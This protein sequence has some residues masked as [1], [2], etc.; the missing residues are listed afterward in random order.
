M[1]KE[2]D[3]TFQSRDEAIMDMERLLVPTELL[4]DR[5]DYLADFKNPD[6]GSETWEFQQRNQI[7]S[8][9]DRDYLSWLAEEGL[10]N[11]PDWEVE[12]EPAGDGA[13]VPAG[14]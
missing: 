8:V 3:M 6:F 7:H 4:K 10:E 11:L 9:K 5:L 1:S 12:P 2:Y 13:G 14:E